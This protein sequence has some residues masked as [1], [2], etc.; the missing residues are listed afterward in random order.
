MDR[1]KAEDTVADPIML[2]NQMHIINI[3]NIVQL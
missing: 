1:A 3:K 2:K